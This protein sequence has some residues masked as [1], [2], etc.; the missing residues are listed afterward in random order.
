MV[1]CFIPFYITLY[2]ILLLRSKHAYV[3]PSGLYPCLGY[4][5]APGRS[6]T[7]HKWSSINSSTVVFNILTFYEMM[8]CVLLERILRLCFLRWTNSKALLALT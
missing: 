6:L 5:W 8:L 2:F 7:Q 3:A 1:V 4:S